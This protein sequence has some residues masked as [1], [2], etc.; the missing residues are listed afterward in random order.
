MSAVAT[1]LAEMGHRVTGHD[2]SADSPFLLRSRPSG[3]TSPPAR[4]RT[5]RRG[6][7][8]RGL[9]GHPGR[10]P[11]GGG[12]PASGASPCGTGPAPSP[13]SAPGATPWPSPA[14][15][16]RPPP[17][18]SWPRSWRAPAGT[19]GWVVGAG[20][21]GLG[22]SATWGGGGPARRRGR[23]ERRHLPR[24]RRV[25]RAW[26]PTSSPTTSSTGAASRPFGRPSSASWPPCRA[27]ACCAP[28]T[29]GPLALVG[30]RGR[31]RHL[32]HR[33]RTP[34]T[35]STTSWPTG[36]GVA[37]TLVH[38]GER[39]AVAVPAAPG[40]H[41]ARNAAG[42]LAVAA[43]ARRAARGGRPP[44]SARFRGVARRFEVRGEAGGVTVRRQLRP[45]AHRGGRRAGRRP[46]AARGAG[47]CAASSRTATAAPP[48][49]ARLRRRV[50]RRRPPRH[51][52]RLPGGGGP[53][54]RASPASSSSTP[55]STP[56]RGAGGVAARPSTTSSPTSAGA[57]ARRPLPHARRGRPHHRARPAAR[58]PGRPRVSRRPGDRRP[59]PACSATPWR[60]TSPSGPLTTYRVGGPAALLG[61]GRRRGR[62]RRGRRAVAETGVD[63]LVVGK[64][65]NLL[66]ADAGFPGLAVRARRRASPRSRSTAPPSGP[67]ARPPCPWW[68]A[69]RSPPGSPA[70]SGRWACPARSAAACG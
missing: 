58:A 69:A 41:N 22:R 14:P 20:I 24:A 15:T 54:G 32:R 38:G 62:P 10:P 53:R 31:P 36:T 67:A 26:S 48:R 30:R 23:R 66:V 4:R 70:S 52:R 63:V 18:R 16:A 65:S 35:G 7:R 43:P 12:G 51:H 47:S 21:P 9:H 1:L 11:A 6:R 8:A 60:P 56:T 25:G 27:R 2:P 13:P 59:R 44:P 46:A 57:A 40:V 49:W 42:A 37:F 64:G 5:C 3:W 29:R 17:R 50:R 45:P 55:C 39:V 68:P 19:P 61:P 34:T 28:T 33:R